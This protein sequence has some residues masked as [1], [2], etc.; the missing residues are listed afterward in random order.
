M[1]VKDIEEACRKVI[2]GNLTALQQLD[3]DDARYPAAKPLNI[4][5]IR[6]Q[7][8]C[9]VVLNTTV[10]ARE[11]QLGFLEKICQ[12]TMGCL[13]AFAKAHNITLKHSIDAPDVAEIMLALIDEERRKLWKEGDEAKESNP[14]EEEEQS[15]N[16][17]VVERSQEEKNVKPKKSKAVV[18]VEKEQ[19]QSA[20][21]TKKTVR[22]GKKLKPKRERKLLK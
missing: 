7:F 17:E 9:D 6:L 8:N 10:P 22:K 14:S 18:E 2:N 13:Q 16:E 21:K 11:L 3:L 4:S 20:E 19:S 15:E 12:T 5:F 1:Y